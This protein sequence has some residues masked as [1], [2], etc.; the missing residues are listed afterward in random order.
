MQAQLIREFMRFSSRQVIT[1]S[2]IGCVKIA[3]KNYYM[4]SL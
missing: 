4:Q 2:L 3:A 1:G